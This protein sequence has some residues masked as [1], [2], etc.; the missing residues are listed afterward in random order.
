MKKNLLLTLVVILVSS[1]LAGC[2]TS[3][4]PS[5][6]S[7]VKE[8]DTITIAWLPNNSG[9]DEKALRDEIA[10]VISKATGKKVENKLTTDYAI[11]ISALESGDAQLGFF[12]P[13]EYI[14]SHAKNSKII[15]LAVESGDSGTL[16]D[17]LYH[18]RFVVK[19]G[20]EGQYK[21]GDGYD[22]DNMVGKRTS[23]V[24]TSSTSGFNMPAAVIMGKFTK[25]DKWKNLTKDAIAQ[26]GPG[27][28]F[29]QV[30]FA[31]SHQL[32]LFNVL[33]GKADVAAVDDIDVMQYVELSQGQDN[34]PGTVY[35]VK[36]GADAPFDTLVGAQFVVIKSIP[37]DNTPFEANSEFLSQKTLDEITQALTSDQVT[38][39]PKIFVPK[40]AKGSLFAQPH[41][42]L[43]VDDSWYDEMRK[44]LGF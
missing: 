2:G 18:S 16:K 43:K 32:S 23:F 41:R 27:K 17:A 35:T 11:A 30:L 31:G 39:D 4:S 21:S 29:S 20:N 19:K 42:F 36:Q 28:F 40:G 10:S 1:L 6:A 26:G 24:S 14:E 9:N 15:P 12:G 38:N 3:T 37:V 25:Q 13:Y 7:D 5:S 34:E 8:P 33:S 44:V 22:I